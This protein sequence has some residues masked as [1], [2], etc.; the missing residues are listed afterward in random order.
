[1]IYGNSSKRLRHEDLHVDGTGREGWVSG[2][3]VAPRVGHETA[4]VLVVDLAD[5]DEPAGPARDDHPEGGRTCSPLW[6]PQ[7]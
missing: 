7:S 4:L 2:L 5:Q 1:M 3:D 6:C